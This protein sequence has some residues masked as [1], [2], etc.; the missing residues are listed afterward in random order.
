M[1][2]RG[3]CR[4][5]LLGDCLDGEPSIQLELKDAAV[6][7]LVDEVPD[8]AGIAEVVGGIE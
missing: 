5:F 2:P 8:L 1:L 7:M 4:P 6:F 3:V